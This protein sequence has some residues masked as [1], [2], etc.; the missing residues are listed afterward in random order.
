MIFPGT[1]LWRNLLVLNEA[2]PVCDDVHGSTVPRQVRESG[3][4]RH[5]SQS[6]DTDRLV[7]INLGD[8]NKSSQDFHLWIV[9]RRKIVF[10]MYLPLAPRS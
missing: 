2:A 10:S 7:N 5:W 1:Y 3:G 6:A 8:R 4:E 9:G